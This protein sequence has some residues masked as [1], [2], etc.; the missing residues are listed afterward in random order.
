MLLKTLLWTALVSAKCFEPSIAHPPPEYDPK[1]ALLQDAFSEIDSAL[2]ATIDASEYASTSFSV[3]IT[4]SKELLWSRHH[5]ARE[6]NT[7]RPDIPEVNGDALY[8]IASITKAFTVL[9]VLYQHAAGN[10]SLDD[11]VDKYIKELR[12]EQEGSIPWKD[13]TLR[14][15]ASQLSGIPRECRRCFTLEGMPADSPPVAERDLINLDEID[16]TMLGLPPVSRD[17]LIDCDEYSSNYD[18]PCTADDLLKLLKSKAPVFAPNQKSTYSNVAFE[19]L[20]V[21]LERVTKQSFESY[22]D[23][24]IFKPLKML[25]STLSLPS[26]DTGVIPLEPHFWDID[27]G[28]QSPTGG[29]YSSTNDLS[30]YLRYVLTHYN[31]ITHAVNWFN[32]VSPS[33]DL[34]SFYGMPWE[35]F[36]TDRILQDSRRTVRFITKGGSLPGYS[37]VV[38]TIPEY[39][40]G[41]TILVA[42]SRDLLPEIKETISVV[43]VRAAEQL[44]IRQL[45]ERYAGTYISTNSSLNSSMTFVADHRGLVLTDFVSNSTDVLNSILITSMAPKNRPWYAQLVP[46]L[47]YHE[48]KTQQGEEW[49]VLVT[50]Q[51]V[52]SKNKIWD[53]F[54]MTDVEVPLYAGLPLNEV[55]FWKSQ[56]S[57]LFESLEISAFR[58]NLTRVEK[59]HNW[60]QEG[61][62][63][64]EML[65]L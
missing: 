50:E 53:D 11:P 44:A 18:K 31:G 40:L 9:G 37:S 54:C 34:N 45:Q 35:I 8:R 10:L 63:V 39:D 65:E 4:S 19:F 57:G 56:E 6:R 15:L 1:D 30:K 51:R 20:G 27:Q 32:P 59:G 62:E 55:V 14:S 38:M 16:P 58:A 5:T 29:I 17:G 33:Q 12:D 24:A 48:E 28:I 21:V 52:E 25:K 2:T 41:I 46:T 26:D 7:T 23:E 22:I 61:Q 60:S 64:I 47:L 42:G 3:A 13:I 43:M 36:Q 49:R